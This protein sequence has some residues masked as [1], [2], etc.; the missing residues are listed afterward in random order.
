[1]ISKK[2]SLITPIEDY[3]VTKPPVRQSDF[4]NEMKRNKEAEVERV[5]LAAVTIDDD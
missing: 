2:P 1:M 5:R 3:S 4:D